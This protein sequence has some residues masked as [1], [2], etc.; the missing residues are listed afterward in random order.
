MKEVDI[1]N[2]ITGRLETLIPATLGMVVSDDFTTDFLGRESN[3]NTFPLAVVCPAAID[4]EMTDSNDNRRTYTFDILIVQK[5]ENIQS[6]TDIETIRETVMNLFDADLTFG[7]KADGGVLPSSSQ[8]GSFSHA[9]KSWV[10]FVLTLK[11]K[12]LIPLS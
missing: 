1:K 5:G 6:G 3:I 2:Y 11:P 9:D 7:G 8:I 4:S 12:A 10:G